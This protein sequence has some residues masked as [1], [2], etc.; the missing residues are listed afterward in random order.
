M[1]S[2][3]LSTEDFQDVLMVYLLDLLTHGNEV[4]NEIFDK[5]LE[6]LKLSGLKGPLL[7]YVLSM[8]AQNRIQYSLIKSTLYNGIGRT[9][10]N[11]TGKDEK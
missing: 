7:N 1:S 2:I 4:E 9:V 3:I 6:R 10:L 8:D 11:I 5:F